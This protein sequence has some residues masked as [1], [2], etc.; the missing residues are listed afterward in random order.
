MHRQGEEMGKDF[1]SKSITRNKENHYIMIK[2]I[3]QEDINIKIP[4]YIKQILTELRGEIDNHTVIVGGFNM[5][6]STVARSSR[7]KISKKITNLNNSLPQMDLIGIN[8]KFHPTQ[9]NI[10]SPQVHTEHYPG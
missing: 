7:Q 9:Q 8:R 10:H 4:K 5:P 2:S 6:I 3:H 1:Q